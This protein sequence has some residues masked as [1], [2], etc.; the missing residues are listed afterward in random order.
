VFSRIRWFEKIEVQNTLFRLPNNFRA[1]YARMFM[2][3]YPHLLGLFECFCSVADE[4]FPLPSAPA[5]HLCPWPKCAKAV[6]PAAWGCR[7]HWM[8]LPAPLRRQY[9][10]ALQN[11]GDHPSAVEAIE[12]WLKRPL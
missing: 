3:D 2:R 8:M 6:P 9:W 1:F 4:M 7:R 12:G 5:D 11:L 10:I